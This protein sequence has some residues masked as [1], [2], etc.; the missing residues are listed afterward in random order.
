MA[1]ELLDFYADWC[2]PCKVMDPIIEQI[3]GEYTGKVKVRKIDVDSDNDTA[4]SY[5]V[6]SIPTYIVLKDGQEVDR[7]IGSQ[8]KETLVEKIAPHLS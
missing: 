7:A 6:M 3:E 2:G 8:P 5:G 4:Y 1:V